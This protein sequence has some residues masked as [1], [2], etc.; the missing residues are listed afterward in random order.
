MCFVFRQLG[1][2]VRFV[3]DC[4]NE[5]SSSVKNRFLSRLQSEWL[6]CQWGVFCSR[7]FGIASTIISDHFPFCGQDIKSYSK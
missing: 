4:A 1:V 5:K 6:R 2:V 3:V 7:L